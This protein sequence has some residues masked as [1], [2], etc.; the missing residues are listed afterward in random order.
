[1]LLKTLSCDT[2]NCTTLAIEGWEQ[3]HSNLVGFLLLL[4]K[5]FRRVMFKD[6]D[7][8]EYEYTSCSFLCYS[9]SD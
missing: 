4:V 5:Q 9:E 2:R 8:Y 7:E 6:E 1:M 3:V